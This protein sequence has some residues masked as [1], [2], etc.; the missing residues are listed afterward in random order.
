MIMTTRLLPLIVLASLALGACTPVVRESRPTTLAGT[1]WRVVSV[2][3]RPPVLGSEPTA[4]F[5]ATE[6]EG[7]AGCNTYGG[8]YAYDASSGLLAFGNL[9]MTKMACDA[10]RNEVE[11][12]FTQ[13][14][15]EVTSASIDPDGR[16]VL[17]GPAGEIVLTVDAV[18]A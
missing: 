15:A 14:I 16:L 8:I 5:T 2:N 10:A 9:A 18:P 3:G 11:T 13:A 7:S 6:V 4:T 1:A 12:R 17:N